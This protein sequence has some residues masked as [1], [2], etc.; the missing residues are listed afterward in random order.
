LGDLYSD[1][2]ESVT[3]LP[4]LDQLSRRPTMK[5][6]SMPT[7]IA[8]EQISGDGYARAADQTEGRILT[9]NGKE[10]D[11]EAVKK[12]PLNNGGYTLIDA[13]RFEEL[14]L[15]RWNK[16]DNGNGRLYVSR[17]CQMA[18]K[19]YLHREITGAVK[20]EWV[21]H[22]DNDSLNNTGK[23]LRITDRKGNLRNTSKRRMVSGKPTSSRYKG[24]SWDKK[25]CKWRAKIH[26]GRKNIHIGYYKDEKEAARAYDSRAREL[27]GE[28]AW[29]NLPESLEPSAV[30]I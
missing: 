16:Y 18:G 23:N 17:Y 21:D 29:L 8:K 26:L 20:G 28:Y 15:Y 9:A 24:V 1:L 4:E 27:Y 7:T 12:L 30:M 22:I 10:N 2:S 11:K 13:D 14:S 19:V 3:F 6:P 5:E 25:L